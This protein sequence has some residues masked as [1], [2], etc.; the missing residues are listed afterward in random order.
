MIPYR[1]AILVWH[2]SKKSK[3]IRQNSSSKKINGE[4]ALT[5]DLEVQAG[6]ARRIW[7]MNARRGDFRT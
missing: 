7:G 1:E 2:P 3:I 5:D 4:A 6:D